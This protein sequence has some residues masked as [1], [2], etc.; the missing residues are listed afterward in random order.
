MSAP[1]VTRAEVDRLINAR[2][3][4]YHRMLKYSGDGSERHK[5]AYVRLCT[6]LRETLDAWDDEL[7]D[8]G[9]REVRRIQ[10]ITRLDDDPPEAA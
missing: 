3:V 7:R 1:F 2:E 10:P 6:K 4:A 8:A 9:V 5:R